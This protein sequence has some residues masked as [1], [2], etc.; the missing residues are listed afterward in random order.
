MK[1][2]EIYENRDGAFEY[3]NEQAAMYHSSTDNCDDEISYEELEAKGL[4]KN[5][6]THTHTQTYFSTMGR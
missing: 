4:V 6:H 5:K 1:Y 3:R 2:G